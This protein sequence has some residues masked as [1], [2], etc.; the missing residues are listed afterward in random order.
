M[1][2]VESKR[3]NIRENLATAGL[4]SDDRGNKGLSTAYS[5]RVDNQVVCKGFIP[6]HGEIAIRWWTL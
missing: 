6:A 4:A 3:F 1:G 5:T 2:E